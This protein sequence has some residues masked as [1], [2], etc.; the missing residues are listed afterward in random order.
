MTISIPFTDI[1]AERRFDIQ[2]PDVIQG[3]VSGNEALDS[4][5][6]EENISIDEF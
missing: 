3:V 2:A 1:A 6:W 4:Y 5:P